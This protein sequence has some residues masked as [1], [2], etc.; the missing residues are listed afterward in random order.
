MPAADEVWRLHHGE[1]PECDL[2]RVIAERGHYAGRTVPSDTRQGIYATTPG[3]A[4]LAS[5]NSRS[6]RE[7]RALLATALE[8]W[9]ALPEA[10]RY[11]DDAALDDRPLRG[12]WERLAPRDGMILRVTSRDLPRPE[13]DRPPGRR[14]G[15]W[16]R[17]AWNQ[18]YAWFRRDELRHLLPADRRPDAATAAPAS[19]ATRLVRLHLVD[20]VRGQTVPFRESEVQ[21]ASLATRVVE[22][23]DDVLVL[24]I[25]G[26]ARAVAPGRPAAADGND[27]WNPERQERGVDLQLL[28]R[29]EYDLA[30]ERFVLF[31]LVAL[32]TRWGGTKFNARERDLAPA[33]IGFAFTLDDGEP[34]VAPAFV[35]EYRWP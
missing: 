11:L 26:R 21:E 35:W 30:R 22:R 28:G 24:A 10:D 4:L 1:G 15:G 18:D 14:R 33:G 32:G 29:A 23:R 31:D 6:A 27:R 9:E 19:L 2:F 16:K 5:V 3:G 25:E 34:P 12:R 7:V 13:S 17:R 8:R 20:N